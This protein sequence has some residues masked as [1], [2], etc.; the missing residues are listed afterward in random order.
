MVILGDGH[1]CLP[2]DKRHCTVEEWEKMDCGRNHLCL[3]DEYGNGD[4]DTCKSGFIM[5]DGSCSGRL[6]PS[7]SCH[8]SQLMI[9][10]TDCI[11]DAKTTGSFDFLP[12]G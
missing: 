7:A 1:T 6:L 10:L 4:C 12:F 8:R 3:V 9:L 2:L 11:S 5:R